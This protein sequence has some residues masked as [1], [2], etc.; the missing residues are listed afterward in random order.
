MT[1]LTA[2]FLRPCPNCKH[3]VGDHVPAIGTD[4]HHCL[5]GATSTDGGAT[6]TQKCF[7]DSIEKEEQYGY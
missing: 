5:F 1:A 2:K 4:Q 6:H 7:C 3:P